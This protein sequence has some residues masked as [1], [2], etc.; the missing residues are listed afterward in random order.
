MRTQLRALALVTVAA[1]TAACGAAATGG[2]GAGAAIP[3]LEGPAGAQR[4]TVTVGNAMQF[5]PASMVVRAGQP[6]EL[7]LRNGGGIPHDFALAE[8]ASHPVKIEAQGGQTA[9]GAFTID[10]PGTYVFVCTVPGHA[11]AGM[12][13]TITAQ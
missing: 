4:V 13:G 1:L 8:G 6:V 9:R 3:A 5:A 11:A 7:T 10:T 12:R 2:A